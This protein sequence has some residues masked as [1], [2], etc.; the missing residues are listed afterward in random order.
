MTAET[1]M[2]NV[3]GP[4]RVIMEFLTFSVPMA[5]RLDHVRYSQLFI[6]T[7]I[8]DFDS[9]STFWLSIHTRIC[10]LL[11]LILKYNPPTLAITLTIVLVDVRQAFEYCNK[12]YNVV[13]NSGEKL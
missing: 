10:P 5:N 12:K 13:D 2:K 1:V 7:Q 9:H 8:D 11:I 3:M 6:V 4:N